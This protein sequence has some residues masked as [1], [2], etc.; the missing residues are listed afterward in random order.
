MQRTDKE[1]L[2]WLQAQLDK[3]QYTGKYIFRWAS[4]GR[5]IRLH[6]TSLGGAVSDA[7]E[8]IDQAMNGGS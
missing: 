6:E 8:A 4:D 1:R 7:H 2:D 3:L 5:G